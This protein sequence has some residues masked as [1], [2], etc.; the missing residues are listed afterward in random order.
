MKHQLH[1][2][3]GTKLLKK[4]GFLF[5]FFNDHIFGQ[6]IGDVHF[7]ETAPKVMVS[8]RPPFDCNLQVSENHIKAL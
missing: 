5:L 8:V 3:R 7:L 2:T 1:H 4:N 6:S